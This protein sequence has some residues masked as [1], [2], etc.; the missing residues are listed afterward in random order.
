M[1]RKTTTFGWLVI[2]PGGV[3][4]YASE[5]DAV[6]D[7]NGGVV[8][9]ATLAAAAPVLADALRVMVDRFEVW[10]NGGNDCRQTQAIKQARDA[11]RSAV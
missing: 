6:A 11:L 1:R 4:E 3:D 5:A 9:R 8:V 2:R 7:A 10:G